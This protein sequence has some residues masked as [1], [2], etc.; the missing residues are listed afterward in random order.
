MINSLIELLNPVFL[1]YFLVINSVYLITTLLAFSAIRKYVRRLKTVNIDELISLTGALPITLIVPAYNEEATCVE[2]IKSLLML[3]YPEYE[4][5]VVNDGSKDNTL[6]K[7]IKAFD[8][9]PVDRVVTSNIKTKKVKNVYR[10]FKHDNIW[11][12]DKENGGKSDA[13]N[14]GINFCRTPL[15]CAMDAD[16]ILERDALIR[17]VR[18]FLENSAT[19]A[20]GGII[21]IAN[22]CT[23]KDGIV[24]EIRMPDNFIAAFQ[25]LEYFRAFLSSR[26]GWDVLN[27]MLIV[28]GAFGVFRRST[29]VEAGGYSTNTV[30][31]DME[32][33]VRLHRVCREKKIPY[34][35]TFIPDPVAW[36][37]CPSSI[38]TLAR[39][40]DRWQ[41]GLIESL[42]PH[43]KMLFN[44]F[45]GRIGLLAFP[46]FY[47]FE[48]LGPLIEIL[49]YF[50]FIVSL[51]LGIASMPFVIAFFTLTLIFGI[52]ISI[53][54]VALEE[55][56]IQRYPH[57][58]A[59]IKL[60]FLAFIENF[61]YRQ[62]ITYWRFKAIFSALR[63]V[64]EW[65]DMEKKAFNKV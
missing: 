15:F 37:E 43:Q 27:A 25:V 59:L 46:Y 21:R 28:S 64:K 8:L 32:L 50:L 48:M 11:V 31:E 22:G 65:G 62:V 2:S 38:A 34:R 42:I 19:I 58:S 60:F 45:Y 35:I 4:I 55:F 51:A 44:P 13:L 52:A 36:T 10:S 61:G 29:V 56:S 7:L 3:K 24:K 39:Q 18:P 20:V 12:I 33:I 5:L 53:A 6:E 23:I 26:M 49:G 54:A 63:R 14:T 16:S 1:I 17:I 47:F 57:F 30:G 40:R 41:R 9:K